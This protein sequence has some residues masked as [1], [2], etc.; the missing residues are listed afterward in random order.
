MHNM[1]IKHNPDWNNK[2]KYGYVSG[3]YDNLVNRLND[4][5]EEHSE[6]SEF[7]QIFGFVKNEKYTLHYIEI[8]K[9]LSL[10]GSD[11][12]KIEI[13]E[14][15]YNMSLPLL[16]ILNEYLIKSETKQSNEFVSNE[17]VSH[18]LNVLT[19]EFPKLGLDLIKVYSPEEI[20][21]INNASKKQNK[22]KVEQ[23]Y[24]DLIKWHE[25][26]RKKKPIHSNIQKKDEYKWYER[27]YQ[28]LIIEYG[29]EQLLRIHKLYLELAT[30]GGKSYIVS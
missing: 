16:R 7:I 23:D 29:Y 19:I 6:I 20:N 3:G 17:G 2:K 25:E 4:S 11:I 26:M 13:V 1:Y 21:T 28:R 27:E 15:I 22:T 10:I 30:G 14:N 12:K 8:D 9:I 24:H 18:L 5:S